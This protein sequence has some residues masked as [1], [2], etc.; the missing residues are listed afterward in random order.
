MKKLTI[1]LTATAALLLNGCFFVQQIHD[2][3]YE[4]CF[5][6]PEAFKLIPQSHQQQI[7]KKCG[8]QPA[9]KQPAK[10]SRLVNTT[11]LC[12]E[13]VPAPPTQN[14]TNGVITQK[15]DLPQNLTLKYN[16]VNG[17]VPELKIFYPSGVTE[18][19]TRFANGKA[20]GWS[21]GFF[22]SGK[23]RTRFFYQNGKA[24][25]YEIYDESGKLVEKQELNCR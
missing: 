16:I 11:R 21:E 10:P 22:P 17:K 6:H 18:T 25:R 3:V 15:L 13:I 19:H 24:K 5:M 14:K 23:V 1:A 12:N 7:A 20:E 4:D 8:W 9:L 2:K